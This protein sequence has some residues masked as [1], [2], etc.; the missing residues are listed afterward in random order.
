[1]N[2]SHGAIFCSKVLDRM[3]IVSCNIVWI[4][5]GTRHMQ[6]NNVSTETVNT[7]VKR[8]AVT[9]QFIISIGVPGTILARRGVLPPS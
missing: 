2:A 8:K 7:A 6:P 3:N 4:V 9:F 5:V 1:M